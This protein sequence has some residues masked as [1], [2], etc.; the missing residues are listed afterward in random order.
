M[1]S[2][3]VPFSFIRRLDTSFYSCGIYC[4]LSCGW[5][6]FAPESSPLPTAGHI[7]VLEAGGDLGQE[8]G[9]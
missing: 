4:H 5:P 2:K 3:L 8:A 7:S 9:G 1:L 6:G